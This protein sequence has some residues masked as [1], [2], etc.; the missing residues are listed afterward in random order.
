MFL[1]ID[2]PQPVGLTRLEWEKELAEFQEA[3]TPELRALLPEVST[4]QQPLAKV[5]FAQPIAEQLK[6]RFQSESGSQD[7]KQVLIF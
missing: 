2:F 6:S 7:N 4:R 5:Q 3:L 1:G